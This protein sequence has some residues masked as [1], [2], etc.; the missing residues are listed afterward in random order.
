[1]ALPQSL[2]NDQIARAADRVVSQITEDALGARIP[3]AD[4]AFAVCCN[5]GI[6]AP[7]S[8]AFASSSES[9]KA[10]L[11]GSQSSSIHRRAIKSAIP[12]IDW[13]I[14]NLPLP[15][16]IRQTELGRAVT[17]SML[18]TRRPIFA[19]KGIDRTIGYLDGGSAYDLSDRLRCYYNEE[20]G[21]LS[22]PA[23]GKLV[24]HVSLEGRFIGLSWLA[25]ELFPPPTVNAAPNANS[26]DQAA[27]TEAER[28]DS[29][30]ADIARAIRMIQTTLG[31]S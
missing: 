22:D 1:M 15:L 9:S 25:A 4:N 10:H 12:A 27:A 14:Y 16:P 5:D 19:T 24:G 21:N 31:Q 17:E 11:P 29:S 7:A 13:Q 6:R 8:S 2:W 23:T 28:S 26:S 3:E 20:T 18:T 30:D